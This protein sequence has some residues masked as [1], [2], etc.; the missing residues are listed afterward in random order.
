MGVWNMDSLKIQR[1][2]EQFEKLTLA[3]KDVFIQNL[4][5]KL[6]GSDNAEFLRFLSDCELDYEFESG[7]F[8]VLEN[9]STVSVADGS[10]RVK[11][12][13]AK[14]VLSVILTILCGVLWVLEFMYGILAWVVSAIVAVFVFA[15][16][17]EGFSS[18]SYSPP[19]FRG[20]MFGINGGELRGG[21]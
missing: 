4:R 1:L 10:S 7:G 14:N 20:S 13:N 5:Q 3:E 8:E 21:K 6:T 16:L 19:V 17:R 15:L 18:L 12:N 11:I 9:I 2:R